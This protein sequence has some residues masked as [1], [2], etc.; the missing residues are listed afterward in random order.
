[1]GFSRQKYGHGLPFPSPGDLPDPGMEP[2]SPVSPALQAES[3]SAEPSGSHHTERVFFFLVMNFKIYSFSNFEIR[4]AVLLT[5][6]AKLYIISPW[7]ILHYNC[8]FLL[9]LFNSLYLFHISPHVYF[10]L[11][12]L[13]CLLILRKSL[14]SLKTLLLKCNKNVLKKCTHEGYTLNVCSVHT[15]VTPT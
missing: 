11:C 5:V 1:M 14:L 3:L 7:L 10:I 15:C 6:V 4:S 8:K 12:F 2:V 9:F 13:I